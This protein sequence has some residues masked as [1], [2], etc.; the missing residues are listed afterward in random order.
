[1]LTRPGTRGWLQG[2][3]PRDFSV[4]DMWLLLHL[5]ERGPVV[6]SDLAHWQQVN[7]STMTVQVI[8]L[9]RRGLL[10]RTPA[11]RDHRVVVVRLTE[12]GCV[13]ARNLNVSVGEAF[14]QAMVGWTPAERDTLAHLLGRL[15][16]GLDTARE[17]IGAG[18]PRTPGTGRQSH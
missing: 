6:M 18:A 11:V 2:G 3:R 16:E 12:A 9:E 7:R 17:R 14:A 5:S 1:M 10:V 15:V 13:A 4:A 8:H